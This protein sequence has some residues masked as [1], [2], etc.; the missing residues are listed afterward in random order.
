VAA[1]TDSL[2]DLVHGDVE[3]AVDGLLAI[4]GID[5]LGGSA[6]QREI[7]ED[8]L[9]HCA[10]RAGRTELA[11]GILDDRLQ[12][13]ESDRDRRRLRRLREPTPVL[14]RPTVRPP[15]RLSARP[16]AGGRGAGRHGGSGQGGA[17]R[18]RGAV[19]R[20]PQPVRAARRE[21]PV[22]QRGPQR[23]H[24]RDQRQHELRPQRRVLG[25]LRPAG[26]ELDG[27]PGHDLVQGPPAQLAHPLVRADVAQ[28]EQQRVLRCR[29]ETA[30][31]EWGFSP[32]AS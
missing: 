31:C 22:R 10:V 26:A 24:A 28:Q 7:I 13:R 8:T 30:R 25:R 16:G 23:Q 14:T 29:G 27:Q 15:V 20:V 18:G 32:P 5:R 4:A 6:A 19:Q 12:R 9:L 3:R 11:A 17:D 21:L 1:L 2:S